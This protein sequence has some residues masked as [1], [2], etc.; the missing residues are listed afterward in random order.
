MNDALTKAKASSATLTGLYRGIYDPAGCRV[1]VVRTGHTLNLR[2]DLRNHSPGGAAWG[3]SG[4]G[5]AQ[6]ALGLLADY[7]DDDELAQAC[8]QDFKSA[9]IARLDQR[10]SWLLTREQIETALGPIRAAR[11]REWFVYAEAGG[12]V[13]ADTT[14]P[15]DEASVMW[16]GQAASYEHAMALGAKHTKAFN[17]KNGLLFK[18][19]IDV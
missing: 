14:S 15:A 7:L 9:V 12:F 18:G 17:A 1:E 8:Y 11:L 3:Y 6:L 4:S 2:H 10:G 5:P 13:T 16:T 19:S